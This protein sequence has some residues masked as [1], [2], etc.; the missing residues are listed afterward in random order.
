MRRVL[1]CAAISLTL[2]IACHPSR[3]RESA[4]SVYVALSG[5][6]CSV[7]PRTSGVVRRAATP[8]AASDASAFG[9]IVFRA[10][11]LDAERVLQEWRA[12]VW[13]PEG[14]RSVTHEGA[15]APLIV[16]DSLLGAT[17]LVAV[18]AIGYNRYS[19]SIRVRAGYI[20]TIDV[21]LQV[22]CIS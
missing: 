2:A 19:D 1:P 7:G 8:R 9:A 10:Q 3:S 16:V 12:D 14:R 17:H 11:P 21:R 15:G 4:D 13:T 5:A 20:D 18:L 6:D 22:H